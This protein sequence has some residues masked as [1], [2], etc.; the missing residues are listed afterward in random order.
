MKIRTG[1]V[2][3]SSSS[4]FVIVGFKVNDD[5]VIETVKALFGLS[6]E[7]IL[8]QMKENDYYSKHMGTKK[9]INEFCMELLYEKENNKEFDFMR[10]GDSDI[11]DGEII[12]GKILAD[13]GE[14]MESTVTNASTI[15]EDIKK[16]QEKSNN[17]ENINIYTGTR[18]C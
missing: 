11:P 9:D 18:A 7:D 1:F 8:K 5:D 6:N 15:V 10:G 17:N 14:Y 4:S 3:N 12:I 16:I 2:S 13:G